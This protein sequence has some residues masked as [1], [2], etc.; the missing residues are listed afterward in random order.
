MSQTSTVFNRPD[1]EAIRQ[2]ANISHT[3]LTL[4]QLE[5]KVQECHSRINRLQNRSDLLNIDF[6][7]NTLPGGWDRVFTCKEGVIHSKDPNIILDIFGK[8][9][10][11][12]HRKYGLTRNVQ[13]ALDQANSYMNCERGKINFEIKQEQKKQKLF[14]AQHEAKLGLARAKQPARPPEKP[15]LC[16]KI[17]RTLAVP[18]C[19]LKK[20]FL[21]PLLAFGAWIDSSFAHIFTKTVRCLKRWLFDPLVT[22]GAWIVSP[23]A[24][25]FTKTRRYFFPK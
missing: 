2:Y 17:G 13:K 5:K 12:D 25:I 18:F 7:P 16:T 14:A 22:L 15:T 1:L 8:K 24:Y 10:L 19:Y 6:T 9:V 23:F 3:N 11:Q 4:E 20:W 21:D